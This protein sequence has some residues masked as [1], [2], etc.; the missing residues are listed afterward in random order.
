VGVRNTF[1]NGPRAPAC[2]FSTF[3]QRQ[4]RIL[5]P[6]DQP[7]RL[8]RFIKESC[9]K[10]KSFRAKDRARDRKQPGIIGYYVDCR[11]V[12]EMAYAGASVAAVEIAQFAE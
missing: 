11:M 3:A 10:R 4:S 9:T 12:K 5:V 1:F 7:V 6:G 8:G 2:C